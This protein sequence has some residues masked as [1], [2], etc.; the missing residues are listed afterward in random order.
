MAALSL[1]QQ[2]EELARTANRYAIADF[3][4]KMDALLEEVRKTDPHRAAQVEAE[5]YTPLGIID[6]PTA[7]AKLR[8]V[9]EATDASD[10]DKMFSFTT[11][12]KLTRG[13]IEKSENYEYRHQA[14]HF[15]QQTGAT[16][17]ELVILTNWGIIATEDGDMNIAEARF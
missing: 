11:L 10:R 9:V 16:L 6:Y 4:A 8:A 2:I 7:V 17:R 14:L 3:K 15:A 5:H 1:G 13:R 12:A